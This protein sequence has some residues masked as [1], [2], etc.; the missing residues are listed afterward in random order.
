MQGLCREELHD[1]RRQGEE[2]R[3][4]DHLLLQQR[5]NVTGRR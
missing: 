3:R 2:T 5:R 1:Q 4:H